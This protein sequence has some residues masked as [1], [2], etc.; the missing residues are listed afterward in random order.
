M[1]TQSPA[2]LSA[3]LFLGKR[4]G[5]SKSRGK[6]I[7]AP[8]TIHVSQNN[9]VRKNSEVK[10]QYFTHPKSVLQGQAIT[11]HLSSFLCTSNI[12]VSTRPWPHPAPQAC[13][14]QTSINLF[15]LFHK[16]FLGKAPLSV[17][18]LPSKL[19]TPSRFYDFGLLTWPPGS[20]RGRR[21]F[22]REARGFG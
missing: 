2:S 12:C 16:I 7:K 13:F 5:C 18:A 19:S 4:T 15:F 20:P 8:I 1:H 6:S 11:F 3:D 14:T 17:S 22:Q 9:I 21:L 10:K